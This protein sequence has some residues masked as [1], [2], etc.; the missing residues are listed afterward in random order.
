MVDDQKKAEDEGREPGVEDVGPAPEAAEAPSSTKAEA[1]PEGSRIEGLETE[2]ERLKEL[3][4]KAVRA[5]AEYD[6]AAKR[7]Q[8]ELQD[9]RKY[10]IT[11]LSRDLLGVVDNL[12]RALSAVPEDALQDNEQLKTLVTGVQ[13]I[14]RELQGIFEKHHIAVVDPMGD[15]FDPHLHE[16]M[17][18]MPAP[19]QPEGSVAQVVQVGYCLHDRLLRPARVGIAKGGPKQAND[20]EDADAPG[21]RVDTEA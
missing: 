12:R 13:M 3:H 10:G 9:A 15:P 20:P 21:S 19:D 14:E 4:N 16:A 7:A 17:F 11:G 18:E 2:I 1:S 6:N 5:A 8:R